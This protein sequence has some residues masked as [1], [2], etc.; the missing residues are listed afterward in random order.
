MGS[1]FQNSKCKYLHVMRNHEPLTGA[2]QL[3]HL[4]VRNPP[5]QHCCSWLAS[6]LRLCPLAAPHMTVPSR[7]TKRSETWKGSTQ[8]TSGTTLSTFTKMVKKS[9]KNT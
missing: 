9:R 2:V 7:S 1:I 8:I 6:A 4:K 5:C 3:T